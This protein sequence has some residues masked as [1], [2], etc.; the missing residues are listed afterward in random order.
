MITLPAALFGLVIALLMGASFHALRGGNGWRLLLFLGLSVLGFALGQAAG[1][2]F[3][4][5]VFR[6]GVLD[7]GLG[8][9]GSV[10]MLLAGNWL[11]RV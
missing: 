11:V 4:W 7:I 3:G 8:V 10:L 9:L 5:L 2:A 6:F 1:M